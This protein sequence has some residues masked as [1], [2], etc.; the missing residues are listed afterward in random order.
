M[1][2]SAFC[3]FCGFA[4]KQ[5]EACSHGPRRGNLSATTIPP[6][7]GATRC[8]A[9]GAPE[10][11]WRSN[12]DDALNVDASVDIKAVNKYECGIASLLNHEE[13]DLLDEIASQARSGKSRF[14]GGTWK[15]SA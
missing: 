15:L 3:F 6:G 12:V 7:N 2:P 11:V 1:A 9:H 10:P 4:V 13:F 14:S 8:I 5:F